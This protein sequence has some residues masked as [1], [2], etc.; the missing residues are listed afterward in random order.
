MIYPVSRVYLKYIPVVSFDLRC[1]S[2]VCVNKPVFSCLARYGHMLLHSR[3]VAYRVEYTDAFG[4]SRKC[5]RKDLPE[6]EENDDHLM[7]RRER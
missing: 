3:N 7:S 6:L 2:G 5:L 1:Q 4:R